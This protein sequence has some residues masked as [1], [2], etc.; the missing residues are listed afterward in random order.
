MTRDNMNA[1]LL[2]YCD[3]EI[4]SYDDENRRSQI[5]ISEVRKRT[6]INKLI[7]KVRKYQKLS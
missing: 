7:N 2:F 5:H 1:I 3:L 6:E 4:C